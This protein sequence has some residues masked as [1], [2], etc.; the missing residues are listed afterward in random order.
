MLPPPGRQRPTLKRL[1]LEY[2][3]MI[4]VYIA[5]YAWTRSLI[6]ALVAIIVTTIVI[7]MM[8]PKREDRPPR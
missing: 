7:R 1:A 5:V 3:A 8:R 4:L 2:L 6:L